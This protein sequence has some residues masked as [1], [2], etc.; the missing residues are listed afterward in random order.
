MQLQFNAQ[1]VEP[2]QPMEPVPEAWYPVILKTLEPKSVKDKP[3]SWYLAGEMDIIDGPGKGRK[4]FTNLN[5][6]NENPEAVRIAQREL[7]AICYVTGRYV[8]ADTNELLNI[9]FMV[10]AVVAN[11][12][13]EIKGFKDMAGS[14]PGKVGGTAAAQPVAAAPVAM[15]PV[16]AAPQQWQAPAAAAPA[17]AW[18]APAAAP[19]AAPAAGVAPWMRQG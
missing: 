11:G 9:P 12:R 16:A 3:N 19:Q 14:D 1:T 8:I 4:L 7:S 5:I 15:P 10:K 6:G 17:A 2:Q 13:N 18:G